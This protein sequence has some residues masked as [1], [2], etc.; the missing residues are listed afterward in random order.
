[1]LQQLNWKQKQEIPL[2][3]EITVLYESKVESIF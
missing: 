1:M 3:E 2:V